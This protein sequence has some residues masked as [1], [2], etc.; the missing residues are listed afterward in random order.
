MSGYLTKLLA[1]ILIFS[2]LLALFPLQN[3]GSKTTQESVVIT[4]LF[5]PVYPPLAK[6]TRITFPKGIPHALRPGQSEQVEYAGPAQKP[7]AGSGKR[8]LETGRR[9]RHLP[10]VVT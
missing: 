2:G 4:K 9:V 5:P 1:T 7:F 8:R 3:A 6:Q 10:H